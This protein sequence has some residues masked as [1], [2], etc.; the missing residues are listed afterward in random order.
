MKNII[1]CDSFYS[2]IDSL[3]N[4]ISTMEFEQNLYGEEIKDFSYIPEP[5]TDMFRSILLDP[6]EIQ[7]NSGV[8]RKPNSGVLFENF[9]QHALWKC[10]VALEDTTL[11]IHEQEGIKTFFNVENVE[12]F[13][14]NNS[15]DKSKWTTVNSINIK[16]NDFVFIRPWFWHSLEENKL[17]QVFLLN[18]EIKE[19]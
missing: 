14:L 15:F 3:Y 11:H 19:E 9:Y 8:F 5:L 17:V 12:D 18:Q 6:V 2:D 16:K 7:P 13:V 10:I 1:I 4:I